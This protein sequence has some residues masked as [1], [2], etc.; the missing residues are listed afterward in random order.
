MK[1][2]KPFCRTWSSLLLTKCALVDEVHTSN[3]HE[4]DIRHIHF[5][6]FT[7]EYI[8]RD[9]IIV[10]KNNLI[11]LG[12]QGMNPEQMDAV[13]LVVDLTDFTLKVHVI[14][15][16]VM[17]YPRLRIQAKSFN[18]CLVLVPDT[19]KQ[20]FGQCFKINLKSFSSK[21]TGFGTW[22]WHVDAVMFLTER[23]VFVPEIGFVGFVPLS[24]ARSCS[25]MNLKCWDESG[26]VVALSKAVQVLPEEW[27]IN[28]LFVMG[29]DVIVC[30]H[31]NPR[32]IN[33]KK[34]TSVFGF[35]RCSLQKFVHECKRVIEHKWKPRFEW[36]FVCE[37]RCS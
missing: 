13:L 4:F 10:N 17:K 14:A 5:A 27:Q 29:K 37:T 25:K 11:I 9:R 32:R 16:N 20:H 2:D 12:L 30:G 36:E 28:K 1:N 21:K 31:P 22:H 18:E 15:H 3:A 19:Y 6:R 7:Y 35:W 26:T 23:G 33:R 34:K 8:L 24:S